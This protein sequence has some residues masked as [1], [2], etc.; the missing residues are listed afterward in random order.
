MLS[1][2]FGNVGKRKPKKGKPKP[3]YE[4]SKHIAEKGS[5]EQRRELAATEDLEPELLYYFATDKDKQV[6]RAVAGNDGTPMQAD[7]LLAN[8]TEAEVRSEI[9]HKIGRIIPNLTKGENARL[10]DMALEVLEILARDEIP[11]IRAII[12]EE[13]KSLDSVP[14]DI[15]V[16]LAHDAEEIVQAP[17]LEFSPLLSEQE[18]IQI[19]AGGVQGGALGAIARRKGLASSVSEAI[20]NTLDKPAIKSLLDNE[21]A[22]LSEKTLESI[23]VAAP[24]VPDWHRP[25]VERANLSLV[26][27]RRIATFVSAAMVETLI[28]RNKVAAGIEKELRIAV[29]KRIEDDAATPGKTSLQPGPE[30]A[31]KLF[32]KGQLDE[33]RIIKAIEDKDIQL[34]PPALIL[35]SGIDE[36]IVKKML[37]SQSGKAVTAL[38]WKAG[39]TMTT[40]EMV[41]RRVAKVS[42]KNMLSGPASGDFPLSEDELDWYVSYF[43]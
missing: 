36:D 21:T 43:S 15:V 38:C 18:L 10:T 35:L 29:R 3:P 23:S 28:K 25:L 5:P 24:D 39:L 40:A 30:R 8:D 32:D 26:T 41:Q 27:I 34:V 6:R 12:A 4:K 19:I 33:D 9:A 42:P 16:K 13:I 22:Q 2:V 20:A 17:I 1:W 37:E 11:Q 14:K 7:V 31:Q